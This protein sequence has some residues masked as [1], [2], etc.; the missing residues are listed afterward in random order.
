MIIETIKARQFF[1]EIAGL[2]EDA[3]PL[4]R[5]A[6][7]IALEE[8]P[9]LDIQLYLRKLDTL[10]ARAETLIGIDKSPI[11]CIESINEVLF[12]QEGL[13]GNSED[14]YDPRNS[15]LNAV[16]DRRLGIPIT[17]SII[18]IEVA[19]RIGFKIEGMGFP[20]HF[21]I[22]HSAQD[23]DIIIDAFEMGRIL[24][25]NDCQELLDKIHNGEV[26]VNASLLKPM[27]KRAIITRMLY[28]L[29]GI[30]TQKEEHQKA[31]LIIDKILML[32]PWTPS[33]IRDRG[34]LYMETS[35]FAKALAD[36]E[37]YLKNVVSPEDTPNIQSHIKMLRNIVC[38]CN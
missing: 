13:R 24:T 15:C 33:E 8:Y 14:Y 20:G 36:L 25:L 31:L 17:L 2:D 23:R 35:L 30:Y 7:I 21:L 10:A 29:K 28:N 3:F 19:K 5:S 26:T 32:N 9:D 22:K 1:S 37:S 34:L 11:N 38:A 4:D 18:Y 6:L 27:E 16:L 12:V